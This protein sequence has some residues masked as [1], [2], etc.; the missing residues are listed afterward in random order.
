MTRPLAASNMNDRS[1]LNNG[2]GNLREFKVSGAADSFKGYQ[3][4]GFFTAAEQVRT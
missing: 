1:D 2:S 3:D 4:V